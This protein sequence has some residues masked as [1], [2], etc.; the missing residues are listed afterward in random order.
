MSVLQEAVQMDKPNFYIATLRCQTWNNWPEHHQ[1][2]TKLFRMDLGDKTEVTAKA[3][4]VTFQQRSNPDNYTPEKTEL[5]PLIW[6]GEVD[7][8]YMCRDAVLMP[9]GDT[10]TVGLQ[11]ENTRKGEIDIDVVVEVYGELPSIATDSLR[12]VAVSLLSLLNLRLGDFL[13]PC[14]PLQ[15]SRA[16][17]SGREVQT[18]FSLAVQNKNS[19]TP[20][21]VLE[22]VREFY[23]K[24]LL[25]Q[26][27]KKLQT[28]LEVFGSHF[29]ERSAKA[30][31]LLLV[32]AMEV[33]ATP[34]AKHEAALNLMDRWQA[35]LATE[36]AK[37]TNEAPEF[38]ALAALER[39]L[40]FRREDSIRSQVRALMCRVLESSDNALDNLP[41]RALHIYDKRSEL[42]H[43]GTLP[44]SEIHDLELEARKLLEAA[45]RSLLDSHSD[46][47]SS[48]GTV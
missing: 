36:K 25:G 46:N 24:V 19:L 28:A 47:E 11:Y 15:F 10:A 27:S 14:G 37:F 34:T 16:L 29:F 21:M 39:E 6:R 32:T 45:I 22:A 30:R 1:F 2:E 40:I 3:A 38:V 44:A 8:F 4:V 20:D 26:Q 31:F 13:T 7:G 48:G 17:T 42:V 5:G 43:D 33:L 12:S 35:E 41:K 18:V 23:Y 9:Q